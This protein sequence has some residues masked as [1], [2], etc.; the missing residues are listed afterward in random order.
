MAKTRDLIY[1][2]KIPRMKVQA[3]SHF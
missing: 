2:F 1:R 3:H